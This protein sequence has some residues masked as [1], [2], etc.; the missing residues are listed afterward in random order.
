M[1]FKLTVKMTSICSVV[2]LLV[3]DIPT[4]IFFVLFLVVPRMR[5]KQT[6]GKM[7]LNACVA[8]PKI[9]PDSNRV[10]P[11]LCVNVL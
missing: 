3:K 1:P 4:L 11:L 6:A 8:S 10:G 7:Y 2:G 5:C 9:P